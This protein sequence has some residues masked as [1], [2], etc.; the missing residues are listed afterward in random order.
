MKFTLAVYGAPHSQQS[1][2]T[3]YRF[4]KAV[5]SSGHEIYRVF[6]YHDGVHNSARL[7]SPPQDE[8]CI[9][10]LWQALAAEFDL[11]LVVCIAAAVRRGVLD[12][13]EAN[14]YEKDQF[15]LADGFE[16]SGLGQLVDAAV[17][18]DR[19]VTFGC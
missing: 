12:Q 13:R 2:Q 1:A 9:P 17:E 3:A 18:A 15:S 6:F 11:D 5:L 10:L 4:A 7:A 16:L 14:R 19:L 8:P